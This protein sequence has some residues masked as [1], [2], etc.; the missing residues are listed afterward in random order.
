MKKLSNEF[1]DLL[2]Y[3][4]CYSLEINESELF[5]FSKKKSRQEA[6]KFTYE[7]HGELTGFAQN[8]LPSSYL[9]QVLL[10]LSN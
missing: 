2:G 8:K 3:Y 4:T 5:D 9:V 6:I 1:R 7:K 10:K